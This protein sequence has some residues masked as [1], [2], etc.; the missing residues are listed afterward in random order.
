MGHDWGG[1]HDEYV[2]KH[3]KKDGCFITLGAVALALIA[4]VVMWP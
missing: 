4:M 3:R 2:G 1:G